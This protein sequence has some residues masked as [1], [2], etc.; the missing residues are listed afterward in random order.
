[1]F[2]MYQILLKTK[3]GN[4]KVTPKKRDRQVF[5][6]KK[7]GEIQ[8]WVVLKKK[9]IKNMFHYYSL[10]KEHRKQEYMQDVYTI[11]VTRLFI[12]TQRV[13]KI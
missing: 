6:K 8:N 13:N 4:M 7:R 12:Q 9:Q 3:K 10:L 1:M 2:G 5:T 11:L